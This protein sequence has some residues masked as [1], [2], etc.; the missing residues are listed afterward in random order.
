MACLNH[1]CVN[2]CSAN[3]C[4]PTAE[5]LVQ[6]HRHVCQCPSG[7]VGD[8]YVKCYVEATILSECQRN[9]DCPRNEACIN[10]L[11]QNP[12]LTNRCGHNADCVTIEHRPTC[13]CQAGQAGNPQIQCF[14][15][16]F[17]LIQ[18]Y[19]HFLSVE[20]SIKSFKYSMKLTL[21]ICFFQR[22]VKR[23]LT[24]PMTKLVRT[25]IV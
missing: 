17:H 8:P 1:Q 7:Y 5:C 13:Q 4:S 10:H 12:C 20:Y 23:I 15:R 2:P 16:K 9:S 24:V 6:N 21:L 14:N 22:N 11:C 3:S 19:T 25:T 18:N